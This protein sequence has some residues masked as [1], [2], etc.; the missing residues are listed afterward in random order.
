MRPGFLSR[1]P[2]FATRVLLFG[3]AATPLVGCLPATFNVR[4]GR[5]FSSEEAN[6]A[7]VLDRTEDLIAV[8]ADLEKTLTAR[9]YSPGDS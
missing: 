7:I 3:L 1:F 5:A 2:P 4:A 6:P 8:R 9:P